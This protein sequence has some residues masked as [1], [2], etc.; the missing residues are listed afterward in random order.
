MS[1]KVGPGLLWR[2]VP[3][4]RTTQAS[5][6]ATCAEYEAED[7]SGAIASASSAEPCRPPAGPGASCASSAENQSISAVQSADLRINDVPFPSFRVLKVGIA[8]GWRAGCLGPIVSGWNV[9]QGFPDPQGFL[10]APGLC[11]WSLEGGAAF[12]APR[13]F[14][15]PAAVCDFHSSRQAS[16]PSSGLD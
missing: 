9:P 1:S 6:A 13:S 4:P 10:L 5:P 3:E 2:V 8:R 14:Y 11:L 16:E 15:G 7:D 12:R